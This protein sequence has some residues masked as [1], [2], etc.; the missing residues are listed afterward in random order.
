[1][2]FLGTRAEVAGRVLERKLDGWYG[3]SKRVSE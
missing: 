2:Y 1:M 3:G